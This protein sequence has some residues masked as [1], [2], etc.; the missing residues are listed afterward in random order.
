MVVPKDAV[1]VTGDVKLYERPA[2]SGKLVTRGFCPNCGAP[3][4]SLNSSMPEMIFIRASSLDDPELFEP[5]MVVFTSRAPS[6]DHID[7][8]LPAF[9]TMPEAWP[10]QE[11]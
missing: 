9:T 4:Y 8:D 1:T 5:K 3:V 11:S 10:K 2:D 7:S 6:W